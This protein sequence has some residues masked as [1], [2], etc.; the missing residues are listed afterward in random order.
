MG[1]LMT[2]SKSPILSCKWYSE[3]AS[4]DFSHLFC[5]PSHPITLLYPLFLRPCILTSEALHM[6]FTLPGNLSPQI[7]TWLASR[8]LSGLLQCHLLGKAFL[9]YP[10]QHFTPSS[11]IS[12]SPSLCYFFS[13]WGCTT[14]K[15]NISILDYVTQK[16]MLHYSRFL[17]CFSH[18]CVSRSFNNAWHILDA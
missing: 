13:F 8:S 12:Y 5:S 15:G 4:W 7:P 9:G 14:I 17:V 18:C 6:L 16:C 10:M 11:D 1:K 2:E 3:L